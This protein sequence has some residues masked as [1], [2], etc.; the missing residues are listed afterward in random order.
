MRL[1]I[2]WSHQDKYVEE[3]Y[4]FE[5]IVQDTNYNYLILNTKLLFGKPEKKS[6]KDKLQEKTFTPF[7]IVSPLNYP[8][9]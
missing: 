8:N 3:K 7:Q 9:K 2:F 6:K 4:G 1:F 5:L